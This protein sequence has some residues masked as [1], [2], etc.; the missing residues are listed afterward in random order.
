LPDFNRHDFEGQD[1]RAAGRFALLA[2]AGELATEY[3]MTG[4]PEGEA[5]KA[6]VDRVQRLAIDAR[7]RQRRAAANH[8]KGFRLH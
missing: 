6:A 8:S 7:T 2:L 4:W 1:K 5:V 3:G